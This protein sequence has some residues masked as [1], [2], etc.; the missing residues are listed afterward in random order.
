MQRRLSIY[1]SMYWRRRSEKCYRSWVGSKDL[2][3]VVR[4]AVTFSLLVSEQLLSL[5][6]ILQLLSIV[7]RVQL[8]ILVCQT[9]TPTGYWSL[10]G[11]WSYAHTTHK[12]LHYSIH[13]PPQSPP[14]PPPP[15]LFLLASWSLVRHQI[16][17]NGS[18]P[19][20]HTR[21]CKKS[22]GRTSILQKTMFEDGGS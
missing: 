14:P 10:G 13:L 20:T 5:V 4:S 12:Y 17:V 3:L 2:V 22:K 8:F 16:S 9:V 19:S 15:T 7:I 11:N 18:W 6:V 21:L 1:T